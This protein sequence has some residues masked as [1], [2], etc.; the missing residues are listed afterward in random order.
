VAGPSGPPVPGA[1]V[2]AQTP[3]PPAA[4]ASL[5]K[6]APERANGEDGQDGEG[7]EAAPGDFDDDDMENSLSLA[8]IEAELKPKVVET[9]DKIADAY[10]RLR[11]L[12]DQDIQN[13]LRNDSLSP[14]QERRY[15]KLKDEII[16]RGDRV[17]AVSLT[18]MGAI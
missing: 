10:K 6:G 7:S 12:Q 2:L 11:R 4:P 8:A 3:A 13:K 9:F 16:R 1:P 5:F 15:K 18:G 17:M 14:A